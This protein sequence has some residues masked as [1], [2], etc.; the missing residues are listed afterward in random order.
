MHDMHD[1]DNLNKLQNL[2]GNETIN[3]SREE[4]GCDEGS[5][6]TKLRVSCEMN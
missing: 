4:W 2:D 1:L 6:K 5:V 3:S